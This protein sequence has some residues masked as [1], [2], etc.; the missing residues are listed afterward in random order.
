M[1][2][3]KLLASSLPAVKGFGVP[4]EMVR[5][6]DGIKRYAHIHNVQLVQIDPALVVSKSS[7]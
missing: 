5:S 1:L 6:I 2:K 3:R 4:R 7:F